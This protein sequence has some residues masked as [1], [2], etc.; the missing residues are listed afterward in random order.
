MEVIEPLNLLK[1]RQSTGMTQKQFADCAKVNLRTYR[2]YERGERSL[3][4][5]RFREMKECLGYRYAETGQN[6]RAMIDYLRVTFKQVVDLKEFCQTYLGCP[7][8]EFTNTATGLMAYNRV[9]KRGNIWVFDYADKADRDNYQVT[10]QLSGQ[11]CREMELIM[12]NLG[13]SWYDLL[14]KMAGRS[15]MQVTRLDIALDELF[16]GFDK[17]DDHIKLSDLINKV[18]L[19]E[20][21]P[22]HIKTWN[23]IGGGQLTDDDDAGQ[24]ISIYF[25]SRQ[26]N[27]Y[28]NFYEKRYEIAKREG[29]DVQESLEVFGVWNRYELRLSQAKAD[30]LVKEFLTGLDLGELAKGLLV[31]EFEVYDGLNQYGA[32][33]PDQKWQALFGGTEPLKLTVKPEPYNIERTVRWLLKQ[34]ADSYAMVAQADKIMDTDHL[35]L[36][37]NSGKINDRGA[38]I[39]KDLQTSQ[40]LLAG[41]R[42]EAEMDSL[43]QFIFDRYSALDSLVEEVMATLPDTFFCQPKLNDPLVKKM[44]QKVHILNVRRHQQ[45]TNQELQ[46]DYYSHLSKY[47]RWLQDL[48][49]EARKTYKKQVLAYQ[50]DKKAKVLMELI[51]QHDLLPKLQKG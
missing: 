30:E 9:W 13:L 2:A 14:A 16:K 32:Y 7:L 49:V 40:N 3:T 43:E 22:N 31:A 41:K 6:L 44:R 17:V 8:S 4:Y 42:P 47:N 19:N 18:Y 46:Q 28:Y 21:R 24:G 48:A 15:D 26:S 5:E 10:L 37:K 1:F 27:C 36:F 25:G 29:I 34:V 20:L 33:Q 35:T 51:V 38:Q 45:P 23:H 39:L 12:A 11:G 50:Q